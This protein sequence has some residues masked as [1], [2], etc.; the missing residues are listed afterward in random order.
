VERTQ[1]DDNM[2]RRCAYA[3]FYWPLWG[4]YG[5]RCLRNVPGCFAQSFVL[6]SRRLLT[7]FLANGTRQKTHDELVVS[8]RQVADIH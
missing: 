2:S 6:E 7:Q 4:R 3:V 5:S 8:G 1:V